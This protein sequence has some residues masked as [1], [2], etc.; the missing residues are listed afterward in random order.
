MKK[1]GLVGGIGPESTLDI[2][3]GSSQVIAAGCLATN[4]RG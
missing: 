1:L 3:R 2:I 4:T